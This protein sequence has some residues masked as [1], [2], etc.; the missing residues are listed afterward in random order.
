MVARINTVAFPSIDAQRI[1]LCRRVVFHLLILGVLVAML[2]FSNVSLA[3]SKTCPLFGSEYVPQKPDKNAELSFVLRIEKGDMCCKGTLRNIF[4]NFDAY[5]KDREKV[6]TMRFGDAWS[7]GVSRQSFSTYYGMYCAFGKD[8]ESK[9]KDMEPSAGFS[10]I[11]VNK[12]LSMADISDAP[13]LLILP[14]TYVT[15]TG[16]S[17]QNPEDWDLYIKFYTDEKVYPDFRGHDFWVRKKCG[18]V[19]E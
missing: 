13:D 15:L 12:D 2:V 14:D 17:Y 8:S 11:G 3:E 16:G 10:V 5:N 4:M 19:G 1:E 6:S 9:C 7:N 18:E